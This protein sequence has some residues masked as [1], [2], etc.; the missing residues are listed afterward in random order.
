MKERT[1]NLSLTALVLGIMSVITV[2][3]GYTV[4]LGIL[5]AMFGILAGA[6]GKCIQRTRTA[7]WAIMISVFGLILCMVVAAALIGIYL[8][9]NISDTFDFHIHDIDFHY[10]YQ[11]LKETITSL[12]QRFRQ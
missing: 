9:S 11:R 12:I 2:F 1:S 10:Y 4:F 6:R 3:G 5:F 8:Y 7:E